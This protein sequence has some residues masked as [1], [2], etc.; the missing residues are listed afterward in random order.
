MTEERPTSRDLRRTFEH[1]YALPLARAIFELE[2][3][4]QSVLITVGQYWCDEATDAVHSEAVAC[5]ERDPTWPL[6]GQARP[7]AIGDAAALAEALEWQAKE[8]PDDPGD[9]NEAQYELRRDACKQAFGQEYFSVLDDNSEMIVAFASYCREVSDQEQP[10]WR[11]HTPYGLV[12]R[13]PTD[14]APSFEVVGPMYR[15][16]WEDRWDVLE[17][18]GIISDW[19]DGPAEPA[20]SGAV[21]AELAATPIAQ[22]PQGRSRAAS[23]RPVYRVLLFALLILAII[24]VRVCLGR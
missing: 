22:R 2:P 20:V 4:C 8:A 9:L 15:P 10:H 3:R 11:A 24:A 14:Q 16:Q 18:D 17:K 12:R 19:D 23:R 6:A 7:G 5:T 1:D 13:P 21:T